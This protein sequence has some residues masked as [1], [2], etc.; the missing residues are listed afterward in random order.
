MCS[1]VGANSWT[2]QSWWTVVDYLKAAGCSRTSDC[3][4]TIDCSRPV[5]YVRVTDCSMT[6]QRS[7]V[8]CLV[9]PYGWREDYWQHREKSKRAEK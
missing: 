8:D 7:V 2:T 6:A 3:S 5:D 1:L 9:I 4:R